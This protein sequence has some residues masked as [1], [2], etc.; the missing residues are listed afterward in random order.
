MRGSPWSAQCGRAGRSGGW[1]HGRWQWASGCTERPGRICV[2][3]SLQSRFVRNATDQGSDVLGRKDLDFIGRAS[4]WGPGLFHA[5]RSNHSPV[6]FARQET[7]GLK[8]RSLQFI[9]CVHVVVDIVCVFSLLDVSISLLSSV[10]RRPPGI[11][12]RG[13]PPESKS[14]G[15]PPELLLHL[16]RRHYQAPLR[17]RL[18]RL[19][20]GEAGP[21]LG[22]PPCGHRWTSS[23][24]L[25]RLCMY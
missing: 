11:S 4:G 2:P 8:G 17:L 3:T 16:V 5:A 21:P 9:D 7:S 19:C 6:P 12:T 1:M 22:F 25:R 14:E 24:Q 10:W 18:L 15:A 23:S 13:S 20:E